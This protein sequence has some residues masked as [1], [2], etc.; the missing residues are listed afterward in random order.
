MKEKDLRKALEKCSKAELI[1]VIVKAE[2]M[3]FTTFSWFKMIAEIKLEEIEAKIDANLAENEKLT[4][5][6]REIVNERCN[7]DINGAIK[8]HDALNNNHTEW[9]QL[10]REYDKLSKELYG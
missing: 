9:E 8:I 7:Y 5:K 4:R 10:N 2:E 6:F 1:E 3:T